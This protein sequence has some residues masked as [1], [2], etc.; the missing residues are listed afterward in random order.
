MRV[1]LDAPPPWPA[2]SVTHTFSNADELVLS[3]WQATFMG[4]VGAD[5]LRRFE[6]VRGVRRGRV[7]NAP[8]GFEGYVAWLEGV[9]VQGSSGP[10]VGMGGGVAALPLP[11]TAVAAT[12]RHE[13][14]ISRDKG[15]GYV[16]DDDGE[17]RRLDGW[18]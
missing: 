7:Y 16:C 4:G 9:M 1:R 2:T 15:K 17:K 6:G 18:C 3:L 14:K 13:R 8:P 11:V 10:G 5:A 12:S